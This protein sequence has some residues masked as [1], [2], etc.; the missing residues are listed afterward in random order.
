LQRDLAADRILPT[1]LRLIDIEQHLC[2]LLP[3]ALRGAVDVCQLHD[4]ELA[5][6]V[7][8][9]ALASKLRQALPRL[10]EGLIGRGWKVS[11]ILLTVQPA[12]SAYKSGIY[13]QSRG[14]KGIPH[15]AL[16]A[17]SGLLRKMPDGEL[18]RAVE[19]LLEHHGAAPV[20]PRKDE[21]E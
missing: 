11:S 15:P 12:R 20:A 6:S 8:S 9:A 1:A 3:P 13:P 17:W 5:L 21:T 18:S 10:Q 16:E 2:D 19:K 7:Q 4:G 14:S